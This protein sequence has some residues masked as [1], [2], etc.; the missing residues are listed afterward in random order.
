MYLHKRRRRRPTTLDLALRPDRRPSTP[1]RP[2]PCH[3]ASP[4]LPWR[5]TRASMPGRWRLAAA[6]RRYSQ[7]Q[8]D[9]RLYPRRRRTRRR[10]QPHPTYLAAS[11]P[12]TAARGSGAAPG[13]QP[14]WGSP[15][16]PSEGQP[17]AGGRPVAH[18]GTLGGGRR[19]KR[20]RGEEG[21]ATQEGCGSTSA[22]DRPPPAPASPLAPA[23]DSGSRG[24][25]GLGKP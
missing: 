6:L 1:S 23:G 21:G 8:A 2:P 16:P 10:L 14:C 25:C 13:A 9:H 24:V 11:G 4:D 15:P 5:F 3:P 17:S 7:T 18:A 20:G 22:D 19:Q 12:S